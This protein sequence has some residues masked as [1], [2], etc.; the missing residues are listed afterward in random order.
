MK[1]YI[2]RIEE[3]IAVLIMQDD[4]FYRISL[5]VPLLPPGCREGDILTLTLDADAAGTGAAKA[6]V[7]GLINKLKK[8]K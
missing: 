2:D 3:G 6:R 8:K 5:P 1:V 7:T 4:L